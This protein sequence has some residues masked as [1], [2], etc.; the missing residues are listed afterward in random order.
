M[1]L[2]TNTAVLNRYPLWKYLML[3][4]ALI[5]GLIYALPNLYGEDPAI[6]VTGKRGT[7]ANEST[8]VL[9][10]DILQQNQ[11][12][13]KFIYLEKGTIFVCFFN[14]DLQSHAQE[15]LLHSLGK[16]YIIAPNLVPATPSWLIK[17]GAKPMKLGLDLRGGVHFLI[18]VD[19]KTVLN[20]LQEQYIDMLRE[21][22]HDKGIPYT[23]MHNIGNYGSEIFF[24]NSATRNQAISLLAPRHR[25]LVLS[26]TKHNSININIKD[27][28]LREV[29]EYAVLQNITI[30][31]NR[32]NQL[33]ITEPLVQRQG[34]DHIIVEL[35]GIQDTTYA[36]NILSA[37][38]T[39][40]FRLVNS[41][42]GKITSA[43][44]RIPV[45]S[46]V[47]T[48]RDGHPVLLYKRVI[49]TG[50]HI[51]DATSNTDEYN[52]PQVHIFLDR[53]GGRIMYNFTKNNIGK[54]MATI[55]SEYKN[56]GAQDTNGRAIFLK[57]E[58]VINIA[59]IQSRLGDSFRITGISN[60]NEARQLSLLL[61]AGALIAP[62][63]IVEEHILGPA[64]GIQNI[65]QGLEACLC[66]LITSITF[67]IV[68][69]RKFGI[70][71]IIALISNLVLIVSIMSLLPG[72]TLTM[73][74]I[75][76]IVLTLGV[77]VDANVL[78]NERIKEELHKGRMVQQAIHIGYHGAFSS[79]FDAN[80]TTLM[81]SII[82]Y[83]IGI[84]SIKGFAITTAIGVATSMFTA[85]IGTR[86]IIN[87][88][89]GGKYINK[90]SI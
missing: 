76:G 89:Y 3:L 52:R 51:I 71:A 11:I 29:R 28:R 36:K 43:I 74:G 46:E 48:T 10:K 77:A 5:L 81:I 54:L 17:I 39:I 41:T 79:I 42:V 78:I 24:L 6:Q 49:L 57:Q 13:S 60:L 34:L 86:A 45:D 15:V 30:L 21:D 4:F 8:L 87:L 40:E 56:S 62:I 90:L 66:G 9:I 83:G 67:M 63:Q 38:A 37:T 82:L 16:N 50:N 73:P 53:T 26:S 7:T 72:A 12:V 33:G 75:A 59:T 25:E 32:V 22:L 61:R 14:Q 85:I 1:F 2:T 20:K 69:Y 23:R 64:L 80:V 27:D 88:L 19:I 70:I 18:E 58:E 68:W 65:T 84:G 55:F 35:P 31:R 47:K 44:N